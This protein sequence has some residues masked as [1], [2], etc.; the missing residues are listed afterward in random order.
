MNIAQI[1]LTLS[2]LFILHENNFNCT[3][4]FCM[5]HFSSILLIF[6]MMGNWLIHSKIRKRYNPWSYKIVFLAL[7]NF[8][9][10]DRSL[11]FNKKIVYCKVFSIKCSIILRTKNHSNFQESSHNWSG[12]IILYLWDNWYWSKSTNCA[13][14][15]SLWNQRSSEFSKFSISKSIVH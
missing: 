13:D 7:R 3:T 15:N 10:Y 4:I 14:D 1:T 11:P 2:S 12:F 8:I 9:V 5:F 6:F